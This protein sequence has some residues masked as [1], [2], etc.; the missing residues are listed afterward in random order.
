MAAVNEIN[1]IKFTNDIWNTYIKYIYS[2]HKINDNENR[3]KKTFF[4]KLNSD[5][6]IIQGPFFHCTPC[7]KPSWSLNELV[8]GKADISLSPK[9]L[10]L[11]RKQFDPDRTLYTHQVKSIQK[12]QQGNNLV[13]ATGTGSGKTE[14]F[15]L[16]ILNDILID[17]S[18]GLRA[19]IIYPM[20]ALADDQLLRLRKLLENLPQVTFGRYTGDTPYENNNGQD[21]SRLINE[22]I[23]RNEIRGNPPHI[24][25]TNFAMLE[26]LMLRPNDSAIFAGQKLSFIVLDEAHTYTGSQGIEISML[27]RRVK[28]YLLNPDK[29]LQFILTSATLGDE[30]KGMKKITSFACDLTGGEFE[31]NDILQGE[32]IDS[33]S[34]DLKETKD[35]EKI[36][37]AI[38]STG[39]INGWNEVI[40]NPEDLWKK[41]IQAEFEIQ[42][43]PQPFT[44]RKIL[45][46]LLSDSS[47]LAKIHDFCREEPAT[48]EV[49]CDKLNVVDSD[50]VRTGIIWL[51]TMGT[52]ARK[53]DDSAPLLPMRFHFFCRGLS[54][55]TVCVNPNCNEQGSDQD[56]KWSKFFLEDCNHCPG[57][58]KKVLPIS[59]CVHCGMPAHKIYIQEKKW[60]KSQKS[61][62]DDQS[63]L[64]LTWDTQI[65]EDIVEEKGIEQEGEVKDENQYAYL[66]LSCGDYNNLYPKEVCCKQKKIIKMVVIKDSVTN[67][68]LKKCPRC[69]G[70][71]GRFESVLRDFITAEDA[72]T[73]VLAES[74]LRNLPISDNEERNRLPANGKNLLVFSDSRQRAAFFAPY[75]SQTSA[76]SAYLGPLLQAIRD[77]ENEAGGY[78]VSFDEIS[79]AYWRNLRKQ[80]VAVIRNKNSIE[81]YFELILTR[82]LRGKHQREIKREVEYVLYKNFCASKKQN[83]NLR[84][85]GLATIGIDFNPNDLDCLN[86]KIPQLFKESEKFGKQVFEALLEIF[87]ER[88]VIKFPEHITA[89]DISNLDVGP[90]GFTFHRNLSG[91]VD[92][93]M[94]FRWNPY[95]APNNSRKNAIRTSRQ[96]NILCKIL[97]KD[98]LQDEE[99]LSSLLENIWD[100]LIEGI[101]YETDWAGE[102]RLDP[103][104]LQVTQKNIQWSVC[105]QCGQISALNEVEC[106]LNGDCK[107]LPEKLLPEKLD[108]KFSKDHYRNRYFLPPLPIVVKEHTAQLSNEIGK[109][110]QSEFINGKVNVLSSSTTFE[111]GIDVGDLKSVLLRNVP[112]SS[113]SYIQRAGRAGRRHDGISA[114]FT[115][116]RNIPHDQFNYQHPHNIIQGIVPPPFIN[117]ANIPLAQRHCNS[118]LLGEF[119]RGIVD[120]DN[121]ELKDN[122]T[123]NKFFLEDIA[124]Q[125]LSDK[126]GEWC[127]ETNNYDQLKNILG[128]VIP[129]ELADKLTPQDAIEM[130][131]DMLVGNV[132]SVRNLKVNMVLERFLEQEQD[133]SSQLQQSRGAER[134]RIA[135]S[136]RSIERLQDQFKRERLINFLSSCSWLPGYAFPQDN[137]KLLV[138]HPDYCERMRLERDREIGIAE[139]APGA[140]VIADGKVF[141]SGGVWYNSKEPEIRWYVRCPECRKIETGHESERPLFECSSCGAQLRGRY[142][143]R[144]YLKPDGFTTLSSEVPRFPNLFRKRPSRVSE[145]FL[146][147]GSDEFHD[148]DIQ[149]IRYGIKKNGKLFRANSNNDFRGFFI[150]RRCGKNVLNNEKSSHETPWGSSCNGRVIQLDMAHE[151]V[152][153]I[154]QLR[155]QGCIVP[156]PDRTDTTFWQSF[157]AGFLNGASNALGISSNDLGGT[158]HGWT[159][160]SYIGELVIYDRI[161]GGAGY[162]QK[163]LDNLDTVL[164]AVLKRV[165]DCKCIDVNSSCYACLRTYSNQ[166]YW[167]ELSR[168]SVVNWLSQII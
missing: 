140:E 163:I 14:C 152:T 126:F 98:K 4:E 82:N 3:L 95:K 164:E 116:C 20:N 157:L 19:I 63:A 80:P 59:T 31:E 45:Y 92:N 78:P 132:K 142:S 161:P 47:I 55:A 91:I 68:N 35:L 75:L 17:P 139:Y 138:R 87:L 112:P 136:L 60:G 81:Q 15:L 94:R 18:P 28:Q 159:E 42:T 16:P 158:Y 121:I 23:T 141:S 38:E 124:G 145:V 110:Y 7:Y 128:D 130:S 117:V 74:I 143:P 97:K 51:V 46:D 83:N 105:P 134:T 167:E 54:G 26:Y 147:E 21:Q 44:T 50:M 77:A 1:A 86:K 58:E 118:L 120:K 103:D 8:H 89:K 131:I 62:E 39:G 153:D 133:L 114:A 156:P 56:E 84:G 93:R 104:C 165:R 90:D 33:F 149:G 135:H 127:R 119:F 115:Y 125:T 122:I 113:S 40:T 155:F 109:K 29:K 162:I 168:S 71:S 48:V 137:V 106:C 66:C 166:F 111:L 146:L 72:P 41:I 79:S 160:Q 150:C 27:I 34:Q 10:K 85:V 73:A 70:A 37:K 144:N 2:T 5:Y 129:V 102:F 9:I 32:V 154:L 67:G 99:Y 13:V 25:L 100:C 64:I 11:P 65:N 12:I 148:H 49:L 88:K 24:L 53:S 107:G 123:V 36:G 69:G 101:L 43:P 96:L 22:R 108:E 151:I 6:S 52:H 76:E 30:E 57:C 61:F